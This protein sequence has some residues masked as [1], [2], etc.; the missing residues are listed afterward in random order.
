MLKIAGFTLVESLIS[1]A[2]FALLLLI[3][4]PYTARLYQKNQVQ[5]IQ[6]EI[7]GAIRFSRLRA[8]SEGQDLVLMP[9]AAS[10]DWSSGMQLMNSGH[11]L[12]EWHWASPQIHVTWHGFQS[13]HFLRFSPDANRY[14]TNGYFFIQSASFPPVKIVVNRLGRVRS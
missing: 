7:K 8:L 4:I 5:V 3:S 2:L 1:L 11:R 14:A 9:R 10:N 13:N 6:D 12:F